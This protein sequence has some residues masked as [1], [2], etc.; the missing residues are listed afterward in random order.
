LQR[1]EFTVAFTK[2]RRF[3]LEIHD[4]FVRKIGSDPINPWPIL[5]LPA[6]VIGVRQHPNIRTLTALAIQ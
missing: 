6:A 3:P 2:K 5:E 1:S 4:R